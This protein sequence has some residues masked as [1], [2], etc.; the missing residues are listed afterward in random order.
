MKVF[1]YALL[2]V[3]L[4]S[5]NAMAQCYDWSGFYVGA[6]VGF[7][8]GNAKFKLDLDNDPITGYFFPDEVTQLVDKANKRAYPSGFTGG[9]QIGYNFVPRCFP[10]LIGLETDFGFFLLKKQRSISFADVDFPTTTNFLRQKIKTDWL[11][12]LRA[13]L[14]Y[15][16]GCWLPYVTGGLAVTR[17]QLDEFYTDNFNSIIL[18]GPD[19]T[20]TDTLKRTAT[21]WAAGG[22]FEY[23]LF[24]CMSIGFNYLY[25]HFSHTKR[26]SGP[27]IDPTLHEPATFHNSA[28]LT[29]QCFRFTVNWRI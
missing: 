27:L 6:N 10:V 17:I 7:A 2:A 29:A 1:V 15:A 3:L 22:G 11:Y 16:C 24:R 12:T 23:A 20:E 9:V 14:G 18:S 21:G 4:W 26:S 8:Q 19:A 5:Q 13:R 28:K 25:T